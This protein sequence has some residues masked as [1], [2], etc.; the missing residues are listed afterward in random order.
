M[1]EKTFRPM[2][3]YSDEAH[4]IKNP[5]AARTKNVKRLAMQAD[6]LLFMTGTALENNVDEMIALMKILNPDVAQEAKK[7]AFMSAAPL[8]RK[9]VSPVYFRRKR[10]DV[11]KELPD[12]IE[13]TEWCAMKAAE[14]AKYVETVYS[15]NFMAMR[16]VSWNV[17]DLKNSTK[18]A[19]MLEIIED[20]KEE[21]RKIIVFSFFL[22]TLDTVVKVLKDKIRCMD[23]ITGAVS[24][25]RRQ[26]ILDEFEKAPAGTVLPAQ[27]QSGGT[28][29]NIQTA[30][31]VI[32]CEPQLK[33]SIE[34]QAVSRAY[35][36]GQTRSVLVYRLMSEHSVDEA[37]LDILSR[38]QKEFDAFADESDAAR[39]SIELEKNEMDTRTQNDIIEAEIV[40]INSEKKE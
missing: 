40:R 26:A 11:L 8:F 20:A 9:A 4:Y 3:T 31:V 23:V 29:L 33:P 25:N 37:M 10:E 30:S 24:P 14:Y 27:I 38:K 6:R 35:R 12:L 19:R 34:N 15:R 32:L 5:E 13:N 18:A 17:P 1:S 39:E 22:E 21:N 36:M 28:G 7:I 2:L 16:R